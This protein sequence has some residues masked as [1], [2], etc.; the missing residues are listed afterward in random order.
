MEKHNVTIENRG[1][2]TITDVGGIDTF[3]EEEVCIQL[4]EGGMIIK[5][6]NLHIQKLDLDS[7][8][9]IIAGEIT[10]LTYMKKGP[11]KKLFRKLKK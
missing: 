8:E 1:T 2:I 11:D 10:A 9:A 6:K 3:D 7:R 4:S 5:G